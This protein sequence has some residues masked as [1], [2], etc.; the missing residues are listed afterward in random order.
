[1]STQGLRLISWMQVLDFLKEHPV[2]PQTKAEARPCMQPHLL[3][4]SRSTHRTVAPPTRPGRNPK[5]SPPARSP[6]WCASAFG[7]ER[8]GQDPSLGAGAPGNKGGCL[9]TFR[10]TA[11]GDQTWGHLLFPRGVRDGCQAFPTPPRASA[12]PGASLAPRSR[13]TSA[14]DAPLGASLGRRASRELLPALASS[15]LTH[16]GAPKSQLCPCLLGVLVAWD[17]I[18][19]LPGELTRCTMPW[20]W[21]GPGAQGLHPTLAGQNGERGH[22]GALGRTSVRACRALGWSS[23]AAPGS[24]RG[25]ELLPCGGAAGSA[26][27]HCLRPHSGRC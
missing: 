18:E 3:L 4:L 12:W 9:E 17:E 8:G 13:R 25:A 19:N 21:A 16:G 24:S 27:L 26:A 1:V 22:A 5:P 23:P 20:G 6:G 11:A 15:T 7:D 2:M 10:K 14:W